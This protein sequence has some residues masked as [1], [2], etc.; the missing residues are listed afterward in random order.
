MQSNINS[1]PGCR[2]VLAG[3]IQERIKRGGRIRIQQRASQPG[4]ANFAN[5]QVLSLV[6]GVTETRFPVPRLEVI[7]N[8]SHFTS[9]ANIEELV[10]IGEF[11]ES[12][13]RIVNTTKPNTS[14]HRETTGR[15]ICSRR[16]EI[17]NSRIRNCERIERIREWHTDTSGTKKRAGGSVMKRVRCKRHSRQGRIEK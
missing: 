12:W 15:I 17:R 11:F 6:N 4:L 1:L 3:E 10:P 8:P 14:S 2:R 5:G 9:Q 7:S 16:K 13:T